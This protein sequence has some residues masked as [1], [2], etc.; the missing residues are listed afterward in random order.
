L[1]SKNSKLRICFATNGPQ[2][3]DVRHVLILESL[4]PMKYRRWRQQDRPSRADFAS[5][6]DAALG[7]PCSN[8]DRDAR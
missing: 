6:L 5:Q 3:P 4:E 8:F 7:L 2:I 1:C